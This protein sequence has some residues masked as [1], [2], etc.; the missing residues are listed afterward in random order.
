[1]PMKMIHYPVNT[2]TRPVWLGHRYYQGKTIKG[3]KLVI[4][5][6]IPFRK[7]PAPT[8]FSFPLPRR[9]ICL[10]FSLMSAGNPDCL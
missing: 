6:A 5:I 7:W 8:W 10:K 4:D 1:L 2:G 9:I 3:R